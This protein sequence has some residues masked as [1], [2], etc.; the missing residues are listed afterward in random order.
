MPAALTA[1]TIGM[2]SSLGALEKA[3]P[4]IGGG[5]AGL[6]EEGREKREITR[7]AIERRQRGDYGM[8]RQEQLQAIGLTVGAPLA[9]GTAGNVA[10]AVG[11]VSGRIAS[12]KQKQLREMLDLRAKAGGRVAEISSDAAL[13]QKELD[14][15]LITKSAAEKQQL[16]AEIGATAAD[17]GI[18][19]YGDVTEGREALAKQRALERIELDAA[20]KAAL[21]GSAGA[22]AGV[23]S[24]AAGRMMGGTG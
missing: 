6:T 15:A 18:G 9:G 1:A 17:V 3:A 19:L 21:E 16:G 10:G 12:E 2:L 8:S 13:R 20:T 14:D 11:P 7:D 5:L 24:G 23:A 4:L 22:A